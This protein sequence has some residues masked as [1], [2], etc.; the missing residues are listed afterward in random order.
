MKTIISFEKVA[1]VYTEP[2]DVVLKDISF[3]ILEGEF[4]CLV[5]ASGSGKSTIIEI[6]AGLEKETGGK[7]IKPAEISMAFQAG[8]LFP[9]L[10]VRENV[11]FGLRAKKENGETDLSDVALKSEAEKYIAM[12]KLDEFKEKY[13]R[14]LSGGQRQ[15]VGIAR[16]LAVSPAVLLLDEPFSALDPVTTAE[17]HDDML[18]I[19][20]TTKK[21]IIMVSHIIEEAVSLAGRI[22]L[23]K[24]KG[25]DMVFPINLP[26]PRRDQEVD[27]TREVLKIRKEFFK[28]DNLR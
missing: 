17:L 23:I 7:V 14:D 25:I 26:Y 11:E 3:E 6:I 12:M 20:Q 18:H 8:A 4:I 2:Y 5:G 21:T 27:F 24:N 15:R 9:W 13:P 10:T 22:F 16:A 19:W 1:K 28:P